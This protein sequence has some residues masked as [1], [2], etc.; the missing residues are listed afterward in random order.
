MRDL[1]SRPNYRVPWSQLDLDRLAQLLADGSSIAQIAD[2]LGRTQESV[3]T[4]ARKAR[5]SRVRHGHQA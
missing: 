2:E 4:R 3:R 1:A 5:M